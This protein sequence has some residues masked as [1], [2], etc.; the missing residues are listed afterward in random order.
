MTA[1]ALPTLVDWKDSNV[2]NTGW[3]NTSGGADRGGNAP[4]NTEDVIFDAN[5]GGAR[6]ITIIGSA[7][8]CKSITTTSSV[9]AYTIGGGSAQLNIGQ[10]NVTLSSN[11]TVGQLVFTTS[12]SVSLTQNGATI[13]GGVV[14]QTGALLSLGGP[15]ST[16]GS[17]NFGNSTSLTTN[18]YSVTALGVSAGGNAVTFNLGSSVINLTGTTSVWTG[19]GNSTMN[20]G[21]S[22]IKIT[23][24]SASL[25]T[26]NSAGKTYSTVWNSSGTGGLLF[27]SSGTYGTLRVDPGCTHL[28][29]TSVTHS[30]T[31]IIAE[32]GDIRGNSGVATLAKVGGGTATVVRCTI[33]DITAS[34]ANTFRAM[35][36]TNVSGNTN[37]AFVG[38]NSNFQ[39]FL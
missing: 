33:R 19:M 4:S 20:A 25:K 13:S 12:G 34:P 2:A 27:D 39:S 36:S 21:T 8:S 17:L 3:S 35:Y 18:N 31:N 10:G 38:P 30:V 1:Y 22:T 26:F 32:G 11:I 5:S 28:F 23:D 7:S 9:N 6:T 16:P 29:Q 24:Q 15:L 37:W 14:A